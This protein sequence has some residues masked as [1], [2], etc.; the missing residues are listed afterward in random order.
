MTAHEV[1]WTSP[2]PLWA[3]I[4]NVTDNLAR[5]FFRR[6]AILRFASDTF[7]NDFMALLETDPQRLAEFRVQPE[8]WRSP[9]TTPT[10]DMSFEKL[11]AFAKRLNRSRLALLQ[12]AGGAS[13]NL[14]GSTAGP[15]STN[16]STTN[17]VGLPLKLFQ[18]AHQR[19]YLITACLVCQML[20]QP[21]RH[22][23]TGAQERVSYVLRRV[24][25][26]PG[27]K[28]TEVNEDQWVE[29]AFVN[30][31]T[32]F[33]WQRVTTGRSLAPN[34]EQNS[35]FAVNFTQDDGRRRRLLAGLIPVGK[36]EIYV[37]TPERDATTGVLVVDPDSPQPPDPRTVLL[38]SQVTEPWKAAIERAAAARKMQNVQKQP[39]LEDEPLPGAA[40]TAS[41]KATRE[42]IQTTSW[43]V[44][45]DLAEF[46]QKY[47]KSVWDEMTSS[48][49]STDPLIVQLQNIKVEPSLLNEGLSKNLFV[50]TAYLP[51]DV[52]TSL[53]DALQKIE[54]E[55]TKL[56]AASR[57][58]NREMRNST[59]QLIR[60]P[61]WPAILF[62]LV[63]P[64]KPELS[65]PG[66]LKKQKELRDRQIA[67][68]DK[69][70]ELIV[71]VLKKTPAQP[72][73]PL[74]LAAQ[75]VMNIN[76]SAWF[77]IRCVFERP[78]CGPLQPTVISDPTEA[79]Q[80]AGFFDP[81][82][83]ARP[84]R[85]ALPI[86]T[87]PAGLR[88][89]D[90]NTAFMISDVL[91]G[92]IDRV[93]SL[94]LGDLVRS[95]L[96]WPLHKDLDVPDGGPCKTDQPP[97][98]SLGMVCSLSIPIITICALILLIIIVFLLDIIFR[99]IPYFILC[100]RLPKFNAKASV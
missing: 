38:R 20:G 11:P 55:R 90:K 64:V 1:Q 8:S 29:Y 85:I 73:P 80:M 12:A 22:I 37:G 25:P 49:T 31:P 4:S 81:A 78:N 99:W 87:S 94:S 13:Q 54:A 82:A 45:L 96:P 28:I 32:G 71:A 36:R 21:D 16:G 76:S 3:G 33:V 41:I 98:L 97:E 75:P 17:Q 44:L 61:L 35:L 92:Q 47:L 15:A 66:D 34:E 89:F 10:V 67:V 5:Q 68:V 60:D 26:P 24:V 58:Y 59:D 79:F 14:P 9:S 72:A 93:K 53:S 30:T 57:S 52:P 74:P 27:K 43:Y 19:Y 40:L 56:E 46:L 86:D 88:K 48:V 65:P 77:V 18:P 6:P 69:L 95:V 50:G 63:D 62:P 2:Q 39:P 7:M 23:E 70:E 83:P 100:F 51:S 91:C 42:Q 84:I